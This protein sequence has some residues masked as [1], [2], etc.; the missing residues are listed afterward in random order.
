MNWP[1]HFQIKQTAAYNFILIPFLLFS[2]PVVL[3]AQKRFSKSE[4]ITHTRLKAH[5]TFLTTDPFTGRRIG[6]DEEKRAAIYIQEQF[7]AGNLK[8]FG[9]NGT[10]L[11]QFTIDEGKELH[12]SSFLI[13][14]GTTFIPGKDF[15][16]FPWS[17][18]T[19]VTSIASPVLQEKETP[20]FWDLKE[21]LD[22]HDG[23]S[24]LETLIYNRALEVQQKGASALLLYNSTGLHTGIRIRAHDT[25]D[26]L[27]IPVLFLLDKPTDFLKG[28]LVHT[29]DLALRIQWVRKTTTGTNIVGFLDFGAPST[30]IITA[31]Y[32]QQVRDQW[33]PANAIPTGTHTNSGGT[34]ALI[35]LTRLLQKGPPASNYLFI[36]FSGEESGLLGSRHF[37]N[38]TAFPWDQTSCFMNLDG[39]GCLNDTTKKLFV[40][41]I[42][43]STAWQPIFPREKKP[44]LQLVFDSSTTAVD[45]QSPFLRKQLPGLFLHTGFQ[46]VSGDA[47][48]VNTVGIVSILNFVQRF[49]RNVSQTPK[50]Q[51]YE[52]PSIVPQHALPT[53][54]TMGIQT[55]QS[56]QGR[57]IL[58]K[59][60]Y[61]G[62]SADAAGLQSG[63]VLLKAGSLPISS[64][65]VF[66]K[67]LY[68][69]KPGDLVQMLILRNQ[70]E[71]SLF[72]RF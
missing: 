1:L 15:L 31:H 59:K 14:D 48:S 50:L 16:V 68:E 21:L 2:F 19:T 57:G 53:S 36:A 64:V 46:T 66:K 5:V 27:S 30:V 67:T 39:V 40:T 58:I 4:F 20:W 65:E 33:L 9:D 72:I 22:Q 52:A 69:Y 28:D 38:H 17:G 71:Q 34:A 13:V 32:D 3:H 41:G 23:A 37:V 60:V 55:D 10:F 49:I 47:G 29:W 45:V 42:P 51:L 44:V 63:D 70:K 7:K 54:V 24:D 62:H 56:Y 26:T 18:N 11:Q 25:R 6:T 12:A 61:P 8:P 35:E 43:S